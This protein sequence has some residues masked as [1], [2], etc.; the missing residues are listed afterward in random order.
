MKIRQIRLGEI[1][2]QIPLG[3]PSPLLIPN[4][5]EITAGYRE[6]HRVLLLFS[7]AHPRT[8]LLSELEIQFEMHGDAEAADCVVICNI[9]LQHIAKRDNK[10][11]TFCIELFVLSMLCYDPQPN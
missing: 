1:V 5:Y 2:T 9:F 3:E 10:C 4:G 6:Y 11:C 7:F 8:V